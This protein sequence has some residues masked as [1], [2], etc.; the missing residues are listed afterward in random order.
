MV[1]RTEIC[2]QLLVVC[3]DQEYTIPAPVN[4]VCSLCPAFVNRDRQKSWKPSLRHQSHLHPYR[5]SWTVEA[6]KAAGCPV[7]CK[8]RNH[9]IKSCCFAVCHFIEVQGLRLCP[10]VNI[11]VTF[12]G[13]RCLAIHPST[14]SFLDDIFQTISCILFTFN[15]SINQSNCYSTNIPGEA[16][17]SGATAKSVFNS[18]IEE[19]VP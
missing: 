12:S 18:K 2:I 16:K 14:F 15:Q 10:T 1:L 13:G 11:D 17:L 6:E 9:M 7:H 19:T 8:R 4:T 3:P 5:A